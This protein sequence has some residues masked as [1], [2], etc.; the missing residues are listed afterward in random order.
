MN[1]SVISHPFV[2]CH[3]LFGWFPGRMSVSTT[4][5]RRVDVEVD[6]ESGGTRGESERPA[7]PAF[8]VR[9]WNWKQPTAMLN[10]PEFIWTLSLPA[11]CQIRR[12]FLRVWALILYLYRRRAGYVQMQNLL[13]TDILTILLIYSFR[14][15]EDRASPEF[16]QPTV[17]GRAT[18]R[19]CVD[20]DLPHFGYGLAKKKC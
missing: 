4:K 9:C 17:F 11:R 2:K 12:K 16:G 8:V 18:F 7:T 13:S 10:T 14:F 3:R 15:C 20:D 6:R 19:V 5:E 1:P